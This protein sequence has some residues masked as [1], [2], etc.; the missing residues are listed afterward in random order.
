MTEY[1]Y[2]CD[3]TYGLI[4]NSNLAI[5]IVIASEVA[6]RSRSKPE[7]D[8]SPPSADSEQAPQSRFF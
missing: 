4:S 7:R 5:R 2:A 3:F 1:L 6:R 8:S